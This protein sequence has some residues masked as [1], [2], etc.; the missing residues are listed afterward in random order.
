MAI[1]SKYGK[2]RWVD[3]GRGRIAIGSGEGQY[4][5]YDLL[6]SALSACFYYTLESLAK[7]M[8]VD[9]SEVTITIDGH[10][11]DEK[12]AMLDNVYFKIE[13]EGVLEEDKFTKACELAGKYCSIHATVAKVAKMH[14]EIVFL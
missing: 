14:H 1:V 10:K 11:R 8:K 3:N 4:R 9:Y 6:Y 7:K 5:P 13:A 12:I 2:D